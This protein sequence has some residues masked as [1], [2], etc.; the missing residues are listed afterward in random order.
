MKLN[1]W[2]STQGCKKTKARFPPPG[3]KCHINAAMR[4]EPQ[5]SEVKL[6]D[7]QDQLWT[8]PS[9]TLVEKRGADLWL[10]R[11]LLR[12]PRKG[13]EKNPEKSSSEI[14]EKISEL[15]SPG[16]VDQQNGERGD[17]CVSQLS[18][19]GKERSQDIFFLLST[20]ESIGY[21]VFSRANLARH[22]LRYPLFCFID[23]NQV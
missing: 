6:K 1:L 7:V 15:W 10:L 3:K 19:G 9:P 16:Y 21:Q 5:W 13:R 20:R 22:F 14:R 17:V 4:W 12:S 2:P 8:R 11:C 18:V 23:V